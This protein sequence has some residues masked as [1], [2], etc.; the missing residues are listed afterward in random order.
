MFLYGGSASGKSKFTCQKILIRTVAE[1]GHRFLI[2]RKVA[3]TCRVSV[4]QLLRDE[5]VRYGWQRLF[6]INRS[7]M[8]ITGVNGSEILFAGLDDSEKLKSIEGITG[9]WMEEAT[10]FSL[11]DYF[12]ID[13]RLRG[14]TNT[15][16]QMILTLNPIIDT[17]WTN[18]EFI[19]NKKHNATILRTTYKDN[20]FI[21]NDYK[22][23][24]EG[25]KG[26][27]RRVY[28]LGEYGRLENTIFNNFKWIDKFPET[29][30]EVYGLDFGYIHPMAFIKIFAQ[31]K[32]LYLQ[33]IVYQ[34][35][36]LIPDFVEKIQNY[37]N[38]KIIADSARPGDISQ[39]RKAGFYNIRGVNKFHDG[40]ISS[41]T[42]LLGYDNIYIVKGSANLYNEFK[43]AQRESDK[44]GNVYEEMI[45]QNDDGIDAVRYGV[46]EEYMKNTNWGVAF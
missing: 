34:R 11:K 4:F 36:L 37:K 27:A 2:V 22:E 15:Y 20:A 9:V 29:D 46:M 7:E 5:I 10:E 24:L 41:V 42:F 44:E 43:L 26:N 38:K 3:K 25:Y 6:K 35:K 21:D 23:L 28:T 31:E 40:R 32:D 8:R 13:R 14:K 18:A 39:I 1:K 16:R 19:V 45:K 17:N 12:E 33:E 30:K